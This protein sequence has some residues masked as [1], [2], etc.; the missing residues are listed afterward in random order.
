L[1]FAVNPDGHANTIHT[2]N[3][4]AP[5]VLTTSATQNTCGL[6]SDILFS[7]VPARMAH[8]HHF[9]P[10]HRET[11]GS[12]WR[13]ACILSVASLS[14][15][16]SGNVKTFPEQDVQSRHV[17]M[18]RGAFP[19]LYAGNR[20]FRGLYTNTRDD[21]HPSGGV[22]LHLSG[23]RTRR[24]AS[25]HLIGGFAF[26][27]RTAEH[28]PQRTPC[29]LAVTCSFAFF[30]YS[31]RGVGEPP[32]LGLPH[33]VRCALRFSQPL[34]ALLPPIPVRVYFASN[35]T[36]GV[37]TSPSLPPL[38]ILRAAPPPSPEYGERGR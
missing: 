7:L 31:V 14:T 11:N 28:Y 30:P 20:P 26:T 38:S 37:F 3:E 4:T 35:D 32:A 12:E 21:I 6:S 8:G 15:A 36:P 10:I 19:A 33:P 17:F 22:S 16:H 5:E 24:P 23:Y 1:A 34:D 18:R 25:R 27:S 2:I 29:A 9:Q 13:Q